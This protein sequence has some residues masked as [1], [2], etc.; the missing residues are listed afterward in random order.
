MAIAKLNLLDIEFSH[1]SIDDVLWKLIHLDDFHPEPASK[2]AH[3]VQGLTILERNNP[4]EQILNTVEEA[5][6]LY[7][8]ELHEEEVG[9]IDIDIMKSSESLKQMV[10]QLKQINQVQEELRFMIDENETTIKQLV[11]MI[12]FGFNFDELL[13]CKY[14][15]VR[16]G[17]IPK[18]NVDKLKYFG[19]SDF[20][21]ES[22]HEGKNFDYCMY[23]TTLNHSV[24]VDNIF[25][26]LYFN[27]IDIP[28][29][30]HG[31]AQQAVDELKQEVNSATSYLK[32]LDERKANIIS[33]HINELN[34]IYNV[35]LVKNRIY[36]AMKYVLVMGT[37]YS[38]SGFC[39]TKDA[40]QIKK[41]FEEIDG[42]KVN[43]K[44]A[45]SDSRL[46]PPTKLSNN[47]FSKPFNMFV[48]MYGVPSYDDFD[49]TTLMAITYCMLFG[50]MYGD[51]GQGLL[52]SL[53]GFIVYKWKGWTLGAVG[54]RLG[55]FA[56]IMGVFFGSVFGNEEILEGLFNPMD[57]SNTM[58]LLIAAIAIGVILILLCMIINIMMN[59]KK[60]EYGEMLFSQNG[61]AGFIFYL[62]L[63]LLLVSAM[64]SYLPVKLMNPVYI[65]VLIVLPV[66][67]IFF[68]EPLSRKMKNE[69][70]FPAGFGGFA[71]ESVFE[72]I[73]I[74]LSFVTNTMSF[75]RVGGFVLS[76]AGMMLVVTTLANMVG[77]GSIGVGYFVVMI[78]GNLFVMCLEGLIVGIQ[79]LRLE[80][81]EMFSRYYEGNGERFRSINEG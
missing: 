11:H 19:N 41:A 65:I 40:S 69:E 29:F 77:G 78:I 7:N 70:V 32:D 30:V 71:V 48:E 3:S 16:F 66:I 6:K 43:I 13:S 23:V 52:L 53:L 76:H 68:K 9:N 1:A 12:N 28:Y 8:I 45:K 57:S 15:V 34:Y 10:E 51:L 47:F 39:E 63:I 79:V 50:I 72:L 80:F 44:D 59:F 81:Y 74:L 17:T 60:K 46:K 62:S 18:D 2:L 25:S 5:S 35:A 36:G 21:F 26:S 75:L 64:T 33:S 20:L 27:K 67:L 54:V 56:A 37:I 24:E 22:F 42:V 49:P 58:T 14:L 38:I 31:T 55:F 61:V 4:Y 73:E